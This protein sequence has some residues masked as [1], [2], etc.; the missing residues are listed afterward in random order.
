MARAALPERRL[1]QICCF[2]SE[3]AGAIM[4]IVTGFL[5][6]LELRR[7]RLAEARLQETLASVEQ[8]VADR[9]EKLSKTMAELKISEQQ[10]RLITD[11]SPVHLFRAG[12]DGAVI[13]LSPAFLSMTG[14]SRERA[15]GYGW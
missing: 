8:Q 10:F 14:L 11:L 6:S 7:R 9:T 5:F 13:F 4:L 1:Q 2:M 3:L 12:P 15:L